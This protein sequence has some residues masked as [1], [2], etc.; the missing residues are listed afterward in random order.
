MIKEILEIRKSNK[1]RHE[2]IKVYKETINRLEKEKNAIQVNIDNTETS[3]NIMMYQ[4]S[5]EGWLA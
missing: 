1:K 2:K 4:N 5:L 3:I